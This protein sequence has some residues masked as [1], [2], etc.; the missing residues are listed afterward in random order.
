MIEKI[1]NKW[2]ITSG[3]QFFTILIVFAIT[4]SLSTWISEPFLDLIGLERTS[5]SGWSYWPV[6][7]LII[8]PIYQILIVFIGTLFGQ[9]T[10]FWNF[11][12]KIIKRWWVEYRTIKSKGLPFEKP[13]CT[14]SRGRTGTDIKVRGILSPLRLP[15]SP[16][17]QQYKSDLKNKSPLRRRPDSNWWIAV[18]QTG[19][20]PLG[21]DAF[22]K[23]AP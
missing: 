3:L 19:A 5:M 17:R 1:K 20:L 13:L 6:R 16:S 11:A 14:E 21:Y 2:R 18:L 8:F 12:K 9:H 7:I 22:N 15:I 10:F 23:K 4:G